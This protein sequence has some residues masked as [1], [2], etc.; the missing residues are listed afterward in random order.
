MNSLQMIVGFFSQV[1]RKLTQ[2]AAWSKSVK[3][4]LRKRF[5]WSE[6]GAETEL[7]A[8]ET[9]P[10]GMGAGGHSP[11]AALVERLQGMQF[12][13]GVGEG[14]GDPARRP[15]PNLPPSNVHVAMGRR[16][17]VERRAPREVGT[18]SGDDVAEDGE[19]C[20]GMSYEEDRFWVWSK[21]FFPM[22]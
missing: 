22:V 15:L 16:Q 13:E 1:R 3:A 18:G 2:L 12:H 19:E 21:Q 20:E 8:G 4:R 9:V 14:E 6:M 11:D 7:G 17:S 5:T 10:G